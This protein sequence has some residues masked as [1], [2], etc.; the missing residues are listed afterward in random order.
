M[1]E[2]KLS[3]P[4]DLT[5]GQAT[6]KMV[7]VFNLDFEALNGNDY[8][9]AER[10]SQADGGGALSLE[11]RLNPLFQVHIASR[12]CGVPVER[13]KELGIGDFGRL[14]TVVRDFFAS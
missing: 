2:F 3:K 1:I 6:A 5:P 8:C 11:P 10:A 14:M 13:L 12:A 9:V 4:L 7:E